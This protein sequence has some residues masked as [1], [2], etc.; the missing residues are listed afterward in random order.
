MSIDF[1]W[2]SLPLLFLIGVMSHPRG[3]SAPVALPCAAFLSLV[4]ALFRFSSPAALAFASTVAGALTALT[5]LSIVF[6]AMLLFSVLKETRALN[7]ITDW[8]APLTTHPVAQL[9]LIGWAFPFLIEGISGFGTPAALAAPLLVGL[10][11]PPLKACLMTL[12]AN[13]VPVTFGAM[14]TPVWF[15]LRE[16]NLSTSELR[17]LAADLGS[18]QL[19]CTVF[20]PAL[21]LSQVLCWRE[22]IRNWRFV[23]ASSAACGLPFWLAAQT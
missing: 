15:G 8:V 19:L 13:T 9:M 14:G 7:V 2:A 5:P 3:L 4:I 21:A 10:G 18:I 20:V 17:G 16:L 1:L 12:I 11:F 6:G 23:V 22:V